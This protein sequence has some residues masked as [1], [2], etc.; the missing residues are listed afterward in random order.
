MSYPSLN[1]S[2]E[3]LREITVTSNIQIYIHLFK[4]PDSIW[5]NGSMLKKIWVSQKLLSYFKRVF[6]PQVTIIYELNVSHIWHCTT[7]ENI[8]KYNG[9]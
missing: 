2:L 7:V 9:T 1:V 3:I 4:Y 6:M 5:R 8:R